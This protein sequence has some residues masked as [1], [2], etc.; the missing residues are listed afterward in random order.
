MHSDTFKDLLHA[1]PFQPFTVHTVSG[2]TYLIDH[3][4][5]A[6]LTRGGRT[7]IINFPVAKV[8]AFA[9]WILH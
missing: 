1:Q 5:F 7:V 4:D 6:M 3:P 8:S 2:E 9:S